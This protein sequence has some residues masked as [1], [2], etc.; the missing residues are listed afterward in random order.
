MK[1]YTLSLIV[2][3]LFASVMIAP[4]TALAV[5]QGQHN[6]NELNV[7]I[8]YQNF[9]GTA[10]FPGLNLDAFLYYIPSAN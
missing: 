1:N 7:S 8:E 5:Q 9:F 3:T 2:F 4:S 6:G 10:D